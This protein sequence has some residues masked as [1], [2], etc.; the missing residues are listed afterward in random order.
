MRFRLFL[1]S[2]VLSLLLASCATKD[3][4]HY[5]VVSIAD[6]AMDVY[7]NN[8]KIARYQ[9]STS[10]FGW[11]DR[12]GSGFT[13]LGELEV[14]RKIGA[15]AALG[16]VFHDRRPTGEILKPD[17]PGRDPIVTR[18]LWLRGLQPENRNAF[19]RCIYIHGTPEERN[20]GRPASYGC[21]RMRSKDVASLFRIVG[22]GARVDIVPGPL[23]D[24]DKLTQSSTSLAAGG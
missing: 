5:V 12:P 6:Q 2:V 9:V 22:V 3:R 17:T 21:V 18:I 20:I 8:L 16:A 14:A 11:G 23:P 13:P 15:G 24:P 4:R 1:G 7:R 19:G 10:K